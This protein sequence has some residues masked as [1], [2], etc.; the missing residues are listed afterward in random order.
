MLPYGRQSISEEDIQAVSQALKGDLITRGEN[1]E[2]F[3]NAIKDYVGAKYAV[4]FSSGSSALSAAYFAANISP[5]D[6]VLTTPNTFIATASFASINGAS[7]D[8][9]D[10][11]LKSGNFALE[12]VFEKMNFRSSR[13]RLFITPVHFAGI[14]V[15]MKL[16]EKQIKDP[17]TVIIEDAAHALGSFYPSGEKVGSSA[18][19]DMTI[20][21]FH[22]VKTITTG[23]GGMVTTNNQEYYLRLKEFR[24]SG[25]VKEKPLLIGEESSDYYEVQDFASNYHMNEMEAALGLSQF[26]RLPLFIEKRRALVKRYR[27][28]LKGNP[29]ITL[30][31]EEVDERTAYHLFVVQID[32]DKIKSSRKALMEKLL[33]KGIGSQFHYIP[34]YRHPVY[35]K[36]FK[37]YEEEFPMMESYY[38]KALSL[39]LYYD[40]KLEDVDNIVKILNE[41]LLVGK[42]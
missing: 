42:Y 37:S 32:F 18:Y 27:E 19:S 41:I 2:K 23:E 16:L 11:D 35:S 28:L 13:G 14:S 5:R 17:N 34:L 38:K 36:Q 6:K 22:P 40:L 9:A 4:A 12:K 15:D 39:P 7:I 30:F 3:E 1:V 25:I 8:F 31:D 21:S 26:S 29:L 24:N 33:E 10:I 20:F